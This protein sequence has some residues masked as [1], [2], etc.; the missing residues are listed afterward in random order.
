MKV[1]C[2]TDKIGESIVFFSAKV[3]SLF[4][5]S[6]S[7][8]SLMRA[9]LQSLN[10][11]T[12][13]LRLFVDRADQ[14]VPMELMISFLRRVA[15]LGHFVELRVIWQRPNNECFDVPECVVHEISQAALANRNLKFLI[16]ATII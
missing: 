6:V 7:S 9:D 10:I 8:S 3:E 16:S 5:I 4:Y 1:F 11:E 15:T 2:Q 13:K 14:T 12:Q